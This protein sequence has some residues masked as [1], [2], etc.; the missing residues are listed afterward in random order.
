MKLTLKIL[1]ILVIPI[2]VLGQEVVNHFS[3]QNYRNSVVVNIQAQQSYSAVLSNF[4]LIKSSTVDNR[5][6][7]QGQER[8]NELGI[9]FFPARIYSPHERRFFQP[10]PKSQY[11]SPYIFVSA[12]PI[13]LIDLN[14][15]EGKPLILY[16]ENH[17]YENGIGADVYDLMEDIPDAHYVPLS[18]FVNGKVG[19]IEEWNGNVFIHSHMGMDKKAEIHI[20]ESKNPKNFKSKS[21]FAHIEEADEEGIHGLSFDGEEMGRLLKGFS[22]ERGVPL[23]N[24]VAGG[25]EGEGAAMAISRGIQ[26]DLRVKGNTQTRVIGLQEGNELF[27]AGPVSTSVDNMEGFAHTRMYYKP[28]EADFQWDTEMIE[29]GTRERVRGFYGELENQQ[30]IELNYIEG[31]DLRGLINGRIP[32][33]YEGRYVSYGAFY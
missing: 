11:Q 24:I 26:P 4:G 16:Q 32:Q 17:E 15:Q 5:Y 27:Y 30:R 10:D 22:M 28:V 18:D 33:A 7:F 12:D 13:N 2:S 6:L 3:I 20:E 29:D 25:C 21:K 9:Y 14:G 8:E 31:D 23:K 1:L 19:D